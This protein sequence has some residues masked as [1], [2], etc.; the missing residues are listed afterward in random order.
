[1]YPVPSY[2]AHIWVIGDVIHLALPPLEGHEQGHTIR[3]PWNPKALDHLL[4]ILRERETQKRPLNIATPAAPTQ[5]DI[6]QVLKAMK[7]AKKLDEATVS[8]L[9]V[10]D[11]SDE[12]LEAEIIRRRNEAST[13]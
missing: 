4:R 8:E 9:T 3:V 2:A 6:E 11:I 13:N 10:L 12:D 5:W 1:M 7:K